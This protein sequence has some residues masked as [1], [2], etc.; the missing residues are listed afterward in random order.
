[1]A[2]FALS[3]YTPAAGTVATGVTGKQISVTIDGIAQQG[4]AFYPTAAPTGK[5]ASIIY[6][7]GGMPGD[8]DLTDA[9]VKGNLVG[10]TGVQPAGDI[11]TG[12]SAMPLWDDSGAGGPEGYVVICP[13]LRGSAAGIWTGKAAAL[14][15]DEFGGAD[16]NDISQIASGPNDFTTASSENLAF[17]GSSSGAMRVLLTMAKLGKTPKCCVLRAPLIGLADWADVQL[18]GASTPGFSNPN[19]TDHTKLTGRDWTLL[20]E[21]TPLYMTDR[22]PIIPYVLVR[23]DQDTTVPASWCE[24]FAEKMKARGAT[25]DIVT[26]PGGAHALTG[27]NPAQVAAT[28][29]RRFLAEHLS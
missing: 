21:R 14:G 18:G 19:E 17:F 8:I 20:R 3:N 11:G 2:S 7:G 6:V 9:H 1:M 28:A 29:I 10:T 26:C 22:L 5:Y 27:A 15:T 23:G 16:L 4:L 24:Q 25:V 13:G 12:L